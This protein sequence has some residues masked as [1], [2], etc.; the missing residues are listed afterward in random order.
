MGHKYSAILKLKPATEIYEWYCLRPGSFTLFFDKEIS[1]MMVRYKTALVSVA[2][3]LLYCPQIQVRWLLFLRER[4]VPLLPDTMYHL[5]SPEV[6]NKLS[7]SLIPRHLWVST[8]QACTWG[9]LAGPYRKKN[10]ASLHYEVPQQLR[11]LGHH[12]EEFGHKKSVSAR[13]WASNFSAFIQSDFPEVAQEK[14]QKKSTRSIS[15]CS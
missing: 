8:D 4:L 6:W 14:L 2:G 9:T 13:T 3:L 10:Q 11:I 5:H 15:N 1:K 12:F 7:S